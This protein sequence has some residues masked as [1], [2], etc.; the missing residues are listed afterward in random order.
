M[1][2]TKNFL[3]M[4]AVLGLAT[5]RLNAGPVDVLTYHNDNARTGQNLS[6]T[7]LTPANVN[8]SSFGKLF[9]VNV[10]GKV[11]AQP[12]VVSGLNIPGKGAHNVLFIATEHDSVYAV[13]ADTGAALWQVTMLGSGEVT[14][15]TRSC[16]QVVP[17]IGVTATPV[18]DR[19]TGPNGTI[20]IIAMSKDGAGNYFQR[21]HALDLTTGA[22]QFGGPKEIAA[23]YPG[24]GDNSTNG[25]VV[26]D[27]KQYK[28][29]PGLLLLNGV[30][31][32]SWSSHCDIRPYN[33]WMIGYNKDTL[34]QTTVFNF[35]PNG[36]HAALWN[37]GFA[38]AVDPAGNIYAL[39]A[40]GTFETTLDGN[41]F[42]SGGDFG[43]GF[44]K[45]ATAN[46][47]LRA[48]DYFTMYNAVSESSND[49]DLGS[50][51]ALVLPD[52]TDASG[53]VRHL[54][55]GA[56][57]DA[58]IYLADRDNMGKFHAG[59]N[60]NLY[61]EVTGQL[62]GGIFGGPAYFNG[63]VY[64][65][66]IGEGV[67]AFP[68]TNARLATAPSSRTPGTFGYPGTTPSIS[69]S[70][71][72]NAILWAA[73]NGTPAVLHAYNAT[74]L[75]HELYNSNQASN[76]RD[77][78]G[79]GNKFIV[80]TIANG[81]VYVGTT[82]GI[83]VFGLFNPPAS[84]TPTATPSPTPS[85]TATPTPSA[86]P[87]PT[88]SSS[89][90]A[91]P[92]PNPS[93][94]PGHVANLSTRGNVARGEGQL[95]GGFIIQGS[96]APKN[97]LLRGIGPELTGRGVPGALLDPTLELHDGDGALLATNDNWPDS[98]QNAQI[99]ATGLAP[100]DPREPA[101]LATL[102]PAAYTAVVGGAGASTGLALVELYDLDTQT[103]P[104]LAN[105]S[106]RGAVGTGDGA[107]IGGVI[108]AGDT[109]QR[110][111]VRALGPELGA[112][113]VANPLSDP[114]LE[115]RDGNGALVAANDN[116]R[117]N[118]EPEIAASGIAP[119]DDRESAIAA[120]LPPANYTAIVRGAGDTTGIAL[121]EI[122]A[123]P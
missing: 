78:F 32:T 6:E 50:G 44:I 116:W 9:T 94:T 117:S 52:F 35:A 16:D 81:K 41:G 97:V 36:T 14:S 15:D 111:I 51:G 34:A 63:S 20:Y 48:A 22:E 95:I 115:L 23:T 109:A 26:F 29:R 19:A 101:I 93:A 45:L 82:T 86:T 61:Q 114:T 102:N 68:L 90:T 83:G 47:Q 69:A 64:F 112:R 113:G 84:P 87:T 12:L 92:T 28:A 53:T 79:T 25:T 89:P 1:I 77:H 119:A 91:T 76:S 38:P 18:I 67:K 27:P 75:A 43:N 40:D 42:P 62:S 60:S 59:D 71:T 70:G 121:V 88:P 99:T 33:G 5:A 31:Y 105:I 72:S 49:Q 10:D 74:D 80:P 8:A 110:V 103:D 3:S 21:L 106:T 104:R 73:Q 66:A 57:K 24:S 7:I 4:W 96:A 46:G 58:N 122:Y 56:G 39:V 65:G 11:D 13:D 54:T 30:V 98:P 55:V 100:T 118:Q 108:V 2:M 120:S 85:A 37:S 17:E 123:L 107:L